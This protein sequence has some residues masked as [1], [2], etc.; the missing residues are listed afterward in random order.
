MSTNSVPSVF[1]GSRRRRRRRR[2]KMGVRGIN[3]SSPASV[4]VVLLR[5]FL[6]LSILVAF[7]R[8]PSVVDMDRKQRRSMWGCWQPKRIAKSSSIYNR[9]LLLSLS[10]LLMLL[11]M[12]LLL[13]LSP[14]PSLLV[15][16]AEERRMDRSVRHSGG[17]TPLLHYFSMA[18]VF[19]LLYCFDCPDVLHERLQQSVDHLLYSPVLLFC[20]H[21]HHHLLYSPGPV[22]LPK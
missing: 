19:L 10:F 12:P 3:S 18:R 5:L 21:H 17:R 1:L 16:T 8:Y 14:S 13:S 2:R 9:L 15:I 4:K 11:L 22:L 20:R 6:F 7:L